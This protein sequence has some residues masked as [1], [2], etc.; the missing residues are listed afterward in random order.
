MMRPTLNEM[1]TWPMEE[2]VMEDCSPN[3][4]DNMVYRSSDYRV[5]IWDGAFVIAYCT[6][7]PVHGPIMEASGDEGILR[8]LCEHSS[9]PLV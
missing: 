8:A 9:A 5:D 6:I 2:Y 4:L 3:V 1:Q 7:G